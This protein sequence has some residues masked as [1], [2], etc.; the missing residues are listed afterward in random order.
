MGAATYCN[1]IRLHQFR[2]RG[3]S[4]LPPTSPDPNPV[5]QFLRW[6]ASAPP[7][8]SPAYAASRG[9]ALAVPDP[10]P[11]TPS[12]AAS[13]G[14]ASTVAAASATAGSERFTTVPRPINFHQLLLISPFLLSQKQFSPT[15]VL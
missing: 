9:A 3:L 10:D 11:G 1:V 13:R 6:L 12:R 4:P 14:A 2:I 5:N 7:S 8:A 15:P